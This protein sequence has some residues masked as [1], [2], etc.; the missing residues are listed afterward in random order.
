MTNQQLR[1]EAMT[2]FLAVMKTTNAMS[3]IWFLLSQHPQVEA[4]L[5]EELKTV[6]GGRTPTVADLRQCALHRGCAGIN[7]A[8]STCMG[9]E[10]SRLARLC[11]WGYYVSWYNC[12][13][14]PVGEPPRLIL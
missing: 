9:N 6:L 11:Y 8:V 1:D 3:W 5:Q 13:P 7:A 12:V 14:E 2:L 10:P 4:R